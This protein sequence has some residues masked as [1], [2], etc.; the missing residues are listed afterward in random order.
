MEMIIIQP[1]KMREESCDLGSGSYNT[2]ILHVHG[3][4]GSLQSC[5]YYQAHDWAYHIHPPEHAGNLHL[6]SQFLLFT[7]YISNLNER[8]E[9]HSRW[10]NRHEHHGEPEHW[11][12]RE[13]GGTR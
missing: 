2:N 12:I 1:D 10:T 8:T 3:R 9:K 4:L 5:H 6:N 11:I 13:E 7:F